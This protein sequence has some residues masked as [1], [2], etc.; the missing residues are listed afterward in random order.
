MLDGYYNGKLAGSG[1]V[2]WQARQDI[3]AGKIDYKEF[4]DIV[5]VVGAV[6][7]PLQHHGHGLDHECAGRGARHVAARLRRDP[8]AVPRARPD[9]LRDRRARGR[10]RARGP[11]AVR[12]PDARRVRERHR[13]LLGDRRL[14]QRAD[15][16]QRHRPACRRRRLSIE[17]WEKVG[18]D[19]PL[20]VNMQPAGRISRRGL[21]PRRRP[22]GGDARIAARPAGCMATR[23]PSTARRMAENVALAKSTNAEVILPYDKP[24]KPHAGFKVLR[25]NLFEFRD[26]EDQR[27]LR[28]IPPALSLRPEGPQCLRG[29]RR[30]VRRTGGLSPPHRRSGA[31]RSTSTRM[32]F[33]RG[34]G[35][36]GYPGSAEVV[37]MQPPAALIKKGITV[38]ALHRR[39]PAVRHVGLAVDPQCLAGSRGGRRA[40]AAA[41]PAT[42]C[43]SISTRAPPIS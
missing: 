12:H 13:R 23:S 17:D 38:A 43:A 40:R 10:D 8:G 18:Y 7:R 29:P 1:T 11:E 28:R 30:G 33:M 31:R 3:A 2:V 24:L 41:R 19:V 15:P 6:D 27:D 5:A 42:A 21:F 37:N 20:L 34:A 22:A 4:I 35:P 36:I 32:L 26:H 25:G 14:D 16:H 9:R 39:R